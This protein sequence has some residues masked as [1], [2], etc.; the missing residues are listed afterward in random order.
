MINIEIYTKKNCPYCDRAKK[1]LIK[2]SLN[3]T[4]ISIDNL[5][6]S[7]NIV[8]TMIERSNGRTTVPQIFINN[9]HIGGSDDLIL[10]NDSGKLDILL[11]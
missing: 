1:L 4:E 10:L 9:K 3:F 6:L 5:Q 7:N 11:K 2:K 8:K